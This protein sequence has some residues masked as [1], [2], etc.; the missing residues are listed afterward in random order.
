MSRAEKNLIVV[1]GDQLGRESAL[2]GASNAHSTMLLIEAMEESEYVWSSRQRTVQFLAAMRHFRNDMRDRGH[3][4]RYR[5]LGASPSIIAG[6]EAEVDSGDYTQVTWMRPGEYRLYEQIHDLL[7]A[8]DV[9]HEMLEDDH[10]LCPLD[11]FADWLSVRKEPRME[12]F[13]RE[14][15]KQHKILM[16]DDGPAGGAWNFDEDNRKA[17][18]KSGPANPAR[19]KGIDDPVVQEVIEVVAERLP[20]HPGSVESFDWPVTPQQAEQRLRA[21]IDDHLADFGKY[22]DAMWTGEPYLHHARIS[23]ALN[24]KLLDPR[25]AIQAAEEAWKKDR[26]PLNAVEGFIRQILGWREYIRGIYFTQMPG[27]LDSN[28]LG[29]DRDLPEFFWTGETHMHCLKQTIEQTLRYGYAHHIQRLMV[30]GLYALLLGVE[31]RQVHEWYLAVYVDAVEWVEAPNTI[32]MSQY[33]DGGFLASKPYVATGKY[34]KR[35]SN[36]CADCPYSPDKRV[37]QDACPFTT[38]YWDFL[39][40]HEDR[41]KSHPRMALQVRNL[42]RIDDDEKEAIRR[43][44]AGLKGAV[45]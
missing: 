4:V 14:M 27:Y 35:M 43:R 19:P 21:F 29:H 20:D 25:T 26:A 8:R 31:P 33:G 24:L 41:F 2:V 1:L 5:E 22:Q 18:P 42:S 7:E 44:A 15:R 3:S 12:Y 38:L 23:S 30:T 11:D 16:E 6:I 10:F 9:D 17:F 39:I 32:G 40:R 37:G 45:S 36:Y 34:I 13:Y 28:E